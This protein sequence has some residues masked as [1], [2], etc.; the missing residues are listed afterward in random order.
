MPPGASGPPVFIGPDFCD[1][2]HGNF[3]ENTLMNAKRS[4]RLTAF[5]LGKVAMLVAWLGVI[6]LNVA[7]ATAGN[8]ITNVTVANVTPSSFSVVWRSFNS[9]PSIKVFSDAAGNTDVTSLL[10]VE[11]L[12]VRT[13][14]ISAADGY[15]RRASV[16]SLQAK[17]RGLGVMQVRVTGCQPNTTYYYQV[18]STASGGA[19]VS[20][21]ASGPLPPVT[22]ALENSFVINSQQFLFDVPGVDTD[23]EIVLLS[24]TNGAYPIAAVVGDGAGTNQVFL[25]V[26]D[27]FAVSGAGNLPLQGSQTFTAQLF[28][29]E[30]II[31]SSQF[32][33]V[34]GTSFAVT[35]PNHQT[36]GIEFLAIDIGSTLLE[37]GQTSSVPISL[38]TDAQVADISIS[39]GIPSGYL[40]GYSLQSLSPAIDPSASTFVRVIGTNY[41]LHLKTKSGQTVTGNQDL[42]ALA[43]T[44]TVGA[45]SAFVPLNVTA[46][47]GL[48]ADSSVV[49]H[50]QGNGGV[51]TLVGDQPLLVDDVQPDGTHHLTLYAK[52]WTG[53]EIDSN[54]D[55]NG[56]APWHLVLRVPTTGLI[57]AIT[58]LPRNPDV[59]AYRAVN[60]VLDPP[61]LEAF[62]NPDHTRKLLIFGLPT[63]QYGVQF[64]TNF[65]SDAVWHP[66]VT[67]TALT[68]SYQYLTIGNTNPTV[69]YRL[70]G[71]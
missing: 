65:Q 35:Q 24:H 69:Y 42:A 48:K 19:S 23:G 9:T 37:T 18:I 67:T 29:A 45:S 2:Q 50:P 28:G 62:D 6:G 61:L 22:T 20:F 66:L 5:G 14:N 7:T 71:N 40:S 58:N 68:N 43:F 55:P 38:Q 10:G 12:P 46:I 57:T 60:L 54:T 49:S 3:L 30:T 4:N 52:P 26:S 53:Y 70:T 21:P 8:S 13:G 64:R 16:A 41:L 56:A 36:L 11:L 33:I 15:D 47:S 1:R 31:V 39:M 44:G 17:S 59:R 27:L 25:N 63:K 32:S 34:F 51:V